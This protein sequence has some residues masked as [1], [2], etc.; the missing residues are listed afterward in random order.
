MK[1][2]LSAF[3]LLELCSL[4]YAAESVV[5][6]GRSSDRS[7]EVRLVSDSSDS[8]YDFAIYDIHLNKELLRLDDVGGYDSYKQAQDDSEALWSS[9]GDFV[10]ITDRYSRHDT[11]IYIVRVSKKS[12]R[13][14][15]IQDYIQNALGRVNATEIDG[16][17]SSN[18]ARWENNDLHVIL[19]FGIKIP[20]G[21]AIYE[22]EAVLRCNEN[23]SFARLIKVSKPELVTPSDS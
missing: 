16:R 20:S 12:S 3:F 10:V 18:V 8:E 4:T 1:L 17:C 2:L 22:C 7:Y 21:R 13:I 11:T 14:L 19:D 6:G 9:S 5:R 15:K 23:D